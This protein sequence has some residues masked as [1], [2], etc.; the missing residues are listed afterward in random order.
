MRVARS[1]ITKQDIVDIIEKRILYFDLPPGTVISDKNLAEELGVGRT[2]VREAL[3]TLK[4]ERLITIIPQSGTFVS[5]IDMDYIKEIA[6]IRHN[7]EKQLVLDLAEKH[8]DMADRLE[9]MILL[10]GVAVRENNYKDFIAYD[11]DFHREIFNI[12][13]HAQ[14]W[15]VIESQYKQTT[16]YDMLNFSDKIIVAESIVEDHKAIVKCVAE[17]ARDELNKLLDY[18]HDIGYVR[19]SAL[20]EKYPSY[21]LN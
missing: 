20:K 18:H 1:N 21:F 12:A 5:M 13:G 15:D 19:H 2:P 7:V 4:Q 10:Q 9:K 6:Y 14:A 16:R 3:L 11:H 8:T 17:D